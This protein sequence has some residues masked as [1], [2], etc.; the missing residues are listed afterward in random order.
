MQMAALAP[1][2]VC[3]EIEALEAIYFEE[4]QVVKT[5]APLHVEIALKPRTAEDQNSQVSLDKRHLERKGL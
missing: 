2:D 5:W 4:C 1:D 3:G